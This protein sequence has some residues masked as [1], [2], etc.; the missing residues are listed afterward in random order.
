MTIGVTPHLLVVTVRSPGATVKRPKGHRAL[1]SGVVG[2]SRCALC[3]FDLGFVN[4]GRN[5]VDF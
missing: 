3:A 4:D 5:L 2:V 1:Y